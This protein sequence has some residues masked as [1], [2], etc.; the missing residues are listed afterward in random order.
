VSAAQL[1]SQMREVPV[2]GSGVGA[3]YILLDAGKIVYVGQTEGL[4]GGRLVAHQ[5]GTR[6]KPPKKFDQAFC[7][8]VP[9]GDLD[10]VEGAL[11]RRFHPRD[12]DKAPVDDSRDAEV[13]ARF[14]IEPCGIAR[15]TFKQTR[16]AR[17]LA[18]KAWRDLRDGRGRLSEAA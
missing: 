9:V 15:A 13:L 2:P 18:V 10:A 12:V 8:E 3:I 1:L 4:G 14:G 11:V 17:W 7:V 6:R 5:R 16:R